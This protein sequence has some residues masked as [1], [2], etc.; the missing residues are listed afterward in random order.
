MTGNKLCLQYIHDEW[1]EMTKKEFP[2]IYEITM[3]DQWEKTGIP[4]PYQTLNC[5]LPD[6]KRQ[7]FKWKY[8]KG[9]VI[10]LESL[11][12]EMKD[13]YGPE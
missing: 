2:K 6:F 3:V 10:T 7:D 13:A 8:P 9:Q 4:L 1:L 5:R 11:G 12:I